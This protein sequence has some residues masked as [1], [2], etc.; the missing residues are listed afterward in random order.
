MVTFPI[1]EGIWFAVDTNTDAS[2]LKNAIL[3]LD[4]WIRDVNLNKPNA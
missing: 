3:I 2:K 1:T 4:L